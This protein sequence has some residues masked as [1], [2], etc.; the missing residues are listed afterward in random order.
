[1]L[2]EEILP[3]LREGKVVKRASWPTEKDISK[4]GFTDKFDKFLRIRVVVRKD[5][6][7]MLAKIYH[8]DAGQEKFKNCFI[9][10]LSTHD[11]MADDWEIVE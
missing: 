6:P 5:K 8:A 7:V 4:A 11:L 10:G 2:F 1:M 9:Y 3:A